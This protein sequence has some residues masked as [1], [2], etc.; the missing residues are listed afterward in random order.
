MGTRLREKGFTGPALRANID[1]PL[2][3][4]EIHGEYVE[5]GAEF[6]LTNSFH[7][8]RTD[9]A[10]HQP[11]KDEL[12]LLY[13]AYLNAAESAGGARVL[14]DI[15][16]SGK[17]RGVESAADV[18]AAYEDQV[19]ILEE[20][21]LDAIFLETFTTPRELALLAGEL[22]RRKP[23]IQTFYSLALVEKPDPKA[24][25]DIRKIASIANGKWGL[26]CLPP[27]Q[28]R[29]RL[30]L[31]ASHG[32]EPDFVRPNAGNAADTL[33]RQ[34]PADFGRECRMLL[35]SAGVGNLLYFGGCCGSTPDH[36]QMALR[37][38]GGG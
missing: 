6:I 27:A 10:P 30:D 24:L 31:L 33:R 35:D 29:G 1:A 26:N 15:G 13:P 5:M 19:E 38:E 20:L 9:Q 16:A 2:L 25:E 36:L 17:F 18:Y 7:L 4:R 32:L 12:A 34:T 11:L 28:M 37:V 21:G 14:G 8:R 23:K 3:V 22:D